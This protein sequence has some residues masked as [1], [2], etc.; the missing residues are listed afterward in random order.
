V[1]GVLG[2]LLLGVAADLTGSFS[3]GL[4]MLMGLSVAMA[5]LSLRLR[6]S[7]RRGA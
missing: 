2:P 4:F 5:F 6:Y 7:L 3:E 1:G